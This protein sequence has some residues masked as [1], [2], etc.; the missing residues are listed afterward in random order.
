M[1]ATLRRELKTWQ[2]AFK[3][4]H[5]RDPTKRD[6]LADT[7]IAGIYDTWQ[8]VGGDT[9]AARS[10]TKSRASTTE[11]KKDG[12]ASSS[13]QRLEV[14]LRTPKKASHKAL[15]SKGEGEE[16][17]RNPFRTPTKASPSKNPW[18]TPSK[19]QTDQ[20][21]G[22]LE[23]VEV[24][25]ARSAIEVEMTPTKRSPLLDILSKHRNSP[26][27]SQ[28]QRQRQYVTASPSKLRT[29]LT[30]ASRLT[31]TKPRLSPTR[32]KSDAALSAALVAYT[33]R[34][35][36]RKRLRGEDV[37]PTPNR[38]RVS[39]SNAL[40]RGEG[41]GSKTDPRA[42]GGK[43]MGL[44]AFGFASQRKP[45]GPEGTGRSV[46]A[47]ASVFSRS[48]S[49]PHP[50]KT[51]HEEEDDEDMGESPIKAISKL[52]RTAS[53]KPGFR[54]LFASPNGNH[55][56][57][58]LLGIPPPSTT[59]AEEDADAVM[60]DDTSAPVGG[61][62]AAELR[63]QR[64]RR[65]RET[66][67]E[68]MGGKKH[69]TK[70]GLQLPNSSDSED[71]EDAGY[72][73][74]S[75]SPA[76]RSG[77]GGVGVSS[78]FTELT[79]PSSAA[80]VAK[81]ESGKDASSPVRPN[82]GGDSAEKRKQS[83]GKVEGWRKV[84][85]VELSDEDE[86]RKPLHPTKIAGGGGK[87]VISITPYQRYGTLRKQSSHLS[88]TA[89][90]DPEEEE[91]GSYSLLPSKLG[92]AGIYAVD[93]TTSSTDSEDDSHETSSSL[94]AGLKLSP[95]RHSPSN[96]KQ[97][98][99][100]LLNS[101]FDPTSSRKKGSKTLNPEARF[102]ELQPSLS[103]S[104]TDELDDAAEAGSGSDVGKKLLGSTGVGS[105]DDDD[106]QNEV[107]EDF[108]FFDSEIELRDIA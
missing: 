34:T 99:D 81:A 43:Q 96:H 83:D 70:P 75:S 46:T 51:A 58:D 29:T 82:G 102:G 13:K 78:P 30:A 1:E 59:G 95:V 64:L 35:K 18:A 27:K 103:P 41:V 2:R 86:P 87:K 14:G 62:F 97:H 74:V 77:G 24:S 60:V 20:Q 17:S 37:P 9:K 50:T 91:F 79:V 4:R 57:R 108:T 25:P 80:K 42:V 11:L 16:S 85:T 98:R 5:G 93:H 32:A 67:E 54:P 19:H 21:R 66:E 52:R 106:W 36:A 107:D 31:P 3:A 73:G 48:R 72:N 40:A 56:P 39:D 71:N 7:E 89:D 104:T 49:I 10:S 44:S 100:R 94:L 45:L 47:P 90:S 53:A 15:D 105:D 84:Q 26:S 23:E 63:Q 55:V 76:Y 101:I 92:S 61:L 65:A 6:I 12:V 88:S 68:E 69:K 8:A 22:A 38:R 28:T 33:P